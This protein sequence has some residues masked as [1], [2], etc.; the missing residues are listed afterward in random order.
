MAP[1]IAAVLSFIPTNIWGMI[2][3]F[4]KTEK[5]CTFDTPFKLSTKYTPALFVIMMCLSFANQFFRNVEIDCTSSTDMPAAGGT[6]GGYGGGSETE[7]NNYCW[8]Y[9]TFLVA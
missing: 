9:E 4:V 5:T 1:T 2:K 8:N 3:K 6:R 7:L